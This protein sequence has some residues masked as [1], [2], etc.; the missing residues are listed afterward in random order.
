MEHS[1]KNCVLTSK[2]STSFVIDNKGICNFCNDFEASWQ[3]RLPLAERENQLN[4]LV[5]EI[6]SVHGRYNCLL[7]LSG[8]VDSSY[9]AIWAKEQGLNPLVVH[10][11]NGWNSELAV[12]NITTIC[13]YCSFDLKTIV[14]DWPEFKAMQ[15]AY[16]K[17]GVV[18]IEVLTDHAIYPTI[19]QLAKKHRLKF[20]ISGFNSATE[21]IMPKDLVYDKRD[22][23]NMKDIVAKYGE[24][25]KI[26]SFPHVSFWNRLINHFFY[27]LNIVQPLNLLDY[28]KADV[29]EKLIIEYGWRDYG[30]KHYESIFTKF[31]QAYILPQIFGID[32]RKAHY[33][34]L[35]SGILSI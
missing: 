13:N 15:L 21:G 4:A 24:G 16:L 5:Q 9:L 6:K 22:W 7:G 19:T 10:F 31:Y 25:K 1:C 17:V 14:I 12:E 8:G 28:N 3:K 2:D 11:Y 27:K 34:S 33:G 20:V 30:G 26:K 18:D 23:S 29:K 35:N 32:K